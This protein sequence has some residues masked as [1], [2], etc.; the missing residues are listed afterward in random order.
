[1][2]EFIYDV[3]DYVTANRNNQHTII[4]VVAFAVSLSHHYALVTGVIALTSALIMSL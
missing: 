2:A 3:I 4:S 1:M